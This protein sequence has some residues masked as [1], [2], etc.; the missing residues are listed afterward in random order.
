MSEEASKE[1]AETRISSGSEGVYV[2]SESL[3]CSLVE[4]SFRTPQ[5]IGRTIPCP[6]HGSHFIEAEE[7]IFNRSP[8]E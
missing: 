2:K 6:I 3:T 5:K 7:T 1:A 4:A 8:Y